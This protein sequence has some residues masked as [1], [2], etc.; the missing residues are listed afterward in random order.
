MAKGEGRTGRTAAP[1]QGGTP[2]GKAA[3]GA[4]GGGVLRRWLAAASARAAVPVPGTLPPP[5]PPVPERAAA[6]ALARAAERSQGLALLA[7][8][9]VLGGASLAEL[10]ETLPEG[11]LI[12]MIEGPG[13]ALGVVALCPLTVASLI[14]MQAM[15]R[16][17]AIPPEPRRPTR[18]DAAIAAD[19]VNLALAELAGAAPA[20]P[21]GAAWAGYRYASHLDDPRPLP[22]MLEDA[23]FRR[24]DAML[25]LG[26]SGGRQGRMVIAV[27]GNETAALRH[28]APRMPASADFAAAEAGGADASA[29]AVAHGARPTLAAA[30][31]TAPITAE[32]ILC[33]R[34]ISLRE[35]RGLVPGA[36][37]SLP[38]AAL[39]EAML[40]TERGQV[41]ARGRLGENDGRYALRLHGAEGADGAEDSEAAGT[42][43]AASPDPPVSA[44]RVPPSVEPPIGDL[45]LPDAFRSKAEDS[46]AADLAAEGFGLA[47]G[48]AEEDD[49]PIPVRIAIP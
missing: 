26:T 38:R 20:L 11:G 42:A 7:E 39:R 14:E 47:M 46:E 17:A 23:G 32:A 25:R 35:L 44:R 10:V 22:L 3:G 27:P 28:D 1:A 43:V 5:A 19:F 34:A 24:L 45:D 21:G 41:L 4:G 40:Q 31:A 16:L 29:P 33:R 12:A 8:S 30:V 36:E 13:E 49:A 37:L 6:A 48:L 15:G 18:T 2:A 9:L